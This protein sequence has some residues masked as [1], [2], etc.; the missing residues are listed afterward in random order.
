[1]SLL[2]FQ[3]STIRKHQV[4]Q[5][6]LECLSCNYGSARTEA[7]C[8]PLRDLPVENIKVL[9]HEKQLRSYLIRKFLLCFKSQEAKVTITKNH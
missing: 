5:V 4:A 1:M 2:I 6:L 7:G 9:F 8:S 3:P